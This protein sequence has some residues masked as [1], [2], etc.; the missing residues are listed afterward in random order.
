MAY[1]FHYNYRSFPNEPLPPFLSLISELCRDTSEPLYWSGHV[2]WQ[3]SSGAVR[4]K[5][6]KCRVELENRS[7]SF[8][9]SFNGRRQIIILW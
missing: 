6:R 8:N 4:E 2:N 3:N 7:Y 9:K 1:L 5:I